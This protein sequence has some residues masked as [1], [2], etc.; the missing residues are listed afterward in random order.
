[1]QDPADIIEISSSPESSPKPPAKSLSKSNSKKRAL[2]LFLP[3]E[4]EEDAKAQ[5]PDVIELTDT[6]EE[7][8]P[9][10]NKRQKTNSGNAKAGPSTKSKSL[11][12]AGSSK[13]KGSAPSSRAGSLSRV[14][15][16]GSSIQIIRC[17]WTLPSIICH[18]DI[19]F[20]PLVSLVLRHFAHY[21]SS[22][23]DQSVKRAGSSKPVASGSG[24]RTRTKAE[25]TLTD[26]HN[27]RIDSQPT[28]AA[29]APATINAI[30]A[31]I[32]TLHVPT[33]PPRTPTPPVR[34]STPIAWEPTPPVSPAPVPQ[35]AKPLDIV[36][37][38]CEVIPDVSPAYVL[39]LAERLDTGHEDD[40][41]IIG[42]VL[43]HLFEDPT[44]PKDVKGKGKEKAQPAD[45]GSNAGVEQGQLDYGSKNRVNRGGPA[46][47]GLALV[48]L[49][50]LS[51]T[52]FLIR[53]AC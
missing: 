11:F 48:S 25:R 15:R 35:E 16:S 23:F 24:S 42:A 20:H 19:D 47:G 14:L 9:A 28:V 21:S 26:V 18:Q 50:F 22:D 32:T 17:V 51:V 31:A 4:T 44:Y 3:D 7:E 37:Q 1:M 8:I 27:T 45:D 13:G 34:D 2:P 46:Y 33:P 53:V 10:P 30:P 40:A 12:V 39:D 41:E 43:H 5:D 36:A 6:E 38:V 49:S 52:G 29:A